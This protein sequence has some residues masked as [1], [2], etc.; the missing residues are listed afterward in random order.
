[1]L[2]WHEMTVETVVDC[3]KT[4]PQGF[5]TEEARRRLAAVGPNEITEGKRRT[6]L[7]MFC[8]QFTDFM[9]LVLLAAAVIS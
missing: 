2:H 8:D 5:S 9:I 6:P 4:S 1:L 3:L 7:R